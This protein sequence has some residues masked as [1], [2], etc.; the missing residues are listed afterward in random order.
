MSIVT[1]VGAGMMGSALCWPLRD[2]GHSVRLVGTPLDTEII[3][4]L[5]AGGPHPRLQRRLPQGVEPY[6]YTRLQTALDGAE[7]VVSGVS[8]FGVE[9]FAAVVGP[10][11][12]PE[13]P[14]IAVTKGLEDQP[15]GDL[16]VLPAA[17]DRRL[18]LHLQ[19]RLSLNA[20]GGPCI[21]HELAARRQT[22]VVFCGSQR[23]VLERLQA[24]F[25]TDYYHIWPSTDLVGV[26][27]AAALKNAYAMGVSLAVGMLDQ[28]GVDGL[29]HMYNPQA[30]LFAQSCWEMQ[31]LL[32][33]V[34]GAE[35]APAGP[36]ATSWLPFPGDLYVTVFGGRT[37]RLGQLLGQGLSFGEASQALAGETLESVA[38][39]SRVGRALPKLA[40]RGRLRL[41]D[42][43]LLAHL[44]EL[45]R[46]DRRVDIPWERFFYQTVP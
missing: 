41:E 13:T 30:A 38:I 39:I 45:V 1:I 9:W 16:L 43:P 2:N 28:A 19:G 44:N 36:S 6:D 22:C 12:R 8:S 5:Q 14:V 18:P 34:I 24:V 20:I 23:S 26:E 10:H 15:D 21:A 46:G 33:A 25:A 7:V 32:A 40:A 42:F 3:S 4:G 35:A 17:T 29:A 31:H 27:M 37:R 11:L